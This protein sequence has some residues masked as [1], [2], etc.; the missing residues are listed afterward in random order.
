MQ[1]ASSAAPNLSRWQGKTRPLRQNQAAIDKRDPDSLSLK[2]E[3][4]FIGGATEIR[5]GHTLNPYLG[6]SH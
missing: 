4:G 2:L 6:M 5:L 3:H 1:P